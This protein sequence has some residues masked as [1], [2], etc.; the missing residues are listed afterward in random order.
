MVSC[1]LE[2]SGRST[3]LAFAAWASYRDPC[4]VPASALAFGHYLEAAA[5]VSSDTQLSFVVPSCLELVAAV[6][7]AVAAG[8]SG[9][10][11]ML[12]VA[13]TVAAVVVA[14]GVETCCFVTDPFAAAFDQS[15][16]ASSVHQSS[17][18]GSARDEH[19]KGRAQNLY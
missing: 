14:S 3:S 18:S 8:M 19:S 13:E 11:A 12:A 2:A 7:T 9:I 5:A 6:A 10:A 16:E 15:A 1:H 17:H 4:S